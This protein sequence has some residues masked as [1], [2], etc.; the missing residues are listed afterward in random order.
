MNMKRAVVVLVMLAGWAAPA[1]A[2]LLGSLVVTMTS[3]ASGST[4]S[5]TVPVSASVSIIGALIVAGV[6]FKLDGANL[7]GEDTS[8][9]YSVSWN[10][11]GASNGTHT[12]SAVARAG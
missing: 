6:Q 1:A 2:Q 5:G 12:L 3:P 11:A 7:G 8:A 4:V 10:T 9:P